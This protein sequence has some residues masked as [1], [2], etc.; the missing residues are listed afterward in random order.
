MLI[1]QVILVNIISHVRRMRMV[2]TLKTKATQ[3]IG[4]LGSVT[5]GELS[6][7]L[8]KKNTTILLKLRVV[9]L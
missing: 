5:I 2:T 9:M 3:T 4:I 7:I 6:G 8:A 1:T